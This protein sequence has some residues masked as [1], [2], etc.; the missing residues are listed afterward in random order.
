MSR[1]LLEISQVT[2]RYTHGNHVIT[3]AENISFQQ[4]AG[5][6][7]VL[8]G[9]SG[10]G[11]ST[12][13]KAI[14][15]FQAVTEGEIRL[16]GKSIA[17]PGPD[18][19]AVFQEFEQLFPWLTV[20]QN[21]IFALRR[22]KKIN[23]AEAEKI[24]LHYLEKVNLSKFQDSYPGALSGGMKQRVAIARAMSMEPAILLMDEPFAALDALTRQKMQQELLA[25]WADTKFTLLFVTHAI[26][27]A[28]IVGTRILLLSAHPGRIVA[29]IPVNKR[30]SSSPLSQEFKR[31]AGNLNDLLCE[32]A[33]AI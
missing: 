10:C 12:L 17:A 16:D 15:G 29:D 14:G 5:E 31:L 24:A 8:L 18:R 21:L 4:A 28:I 7:L 11:K 32:Q 3:A 2:L 1:P 26:D 9:P 25:L 20:K 19:M 33:Y 23:K 27:E 30:I 22:G 6:R 13:L